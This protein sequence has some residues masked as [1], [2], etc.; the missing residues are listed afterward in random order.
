MKRLFLIPALG[1]AALVL[2]VSSHAQSQ[3]WLDDGRT[4][5]SADRQ[6]FYDS[7]R[8][9][10]DTG[11]RE[12][13]KEGER[14]GRRGDVFAYQDEKAYQRA[15]EGYH[16]EYGELERYRQSYRTGFATGYSAGYERFAPSY[17]GYGNGRQRSGDP[18]WTRGPMANARRGYPGQNPDT[19]PGRYGANSPAF[20]N[21]LNDGYEKGAEDSRKRR[22]FD[23]LRHQWYRSG[24]HEYDR[25]FGPKQQYEDTYREAFKRGYERGYREGRRY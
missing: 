2:P 21:G 4:S 22:T 25:R 9:A 1:L 19:Y 15:E 13:L 17:G 3:G 10:Y 12:G 5:Y 6:S 8:A 20:Q 16:R 11:Y 23:P 14:D 24:D 18:N 7:R